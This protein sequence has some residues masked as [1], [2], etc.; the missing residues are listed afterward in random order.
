MGV[1]KKGDNSG[2]KSKRVKKTSLKG[3]KGVTEPVILEIFSDYI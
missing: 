1:D 3:G 2:L